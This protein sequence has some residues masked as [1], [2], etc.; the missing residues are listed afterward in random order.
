M[1][2]PLLSE[3]EAIVPADPL[4]PSCIELK[5]MLD[6]ETGLTALLSRWWS[7]WFSSNGS[8]TP[9]FTA[10]ICDLDCGGSDTSST[11]T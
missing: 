4:N 11:P 8:L 7:A 10:K 2:A 9:A 1:S 5:A 6:G 3:F